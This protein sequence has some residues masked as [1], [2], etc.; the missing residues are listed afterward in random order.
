MVLVA[1]LC[2]P[3]AALLLAAGLPRATRPCEYTKADNLSGVGELLHSTPLQ[4]GE[5]IWA[6]F[7][8]VLAVCFVV[9]GLPLLCMLV[10][11]PVLPIRAARIQFGRWHACSRLDR[12]RHRARPRLHPV[13]LTKP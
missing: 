4:P 2:T 13:V 5:Y 6:R 12:S 1:Q 11:Y 9:L 3:A 7:L 8:A 10:I